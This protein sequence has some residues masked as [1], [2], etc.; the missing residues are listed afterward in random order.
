MCM[1]LNDDPKHTT[2]IMLD[3]T[4]KGR[5]ILSCAERVRCR[6]G[7]SLFKLL[8]LQNYK[9]CA[10]L[11]TEINR[12]EHRLTRTFD[13]RMVV[14]CSFECLAGDTKG[15]PIITT[16]VSEGSKIDE[17]DTQKIHLFN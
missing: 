8:L 14:L 7:L 5:N 15:H 9:V 1:R 17:L 4:P 6:Y 13:V 12:A 11:T 3:V 10:K 2:G 16:S